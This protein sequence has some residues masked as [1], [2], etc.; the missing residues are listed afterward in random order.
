MKHV[1]AFNLGL[2]FNMIAREDDALVAGIEQLAS[3]IGKHPADI[4]ELVDRHPHLFEDAVKDGMFSED[5]C[6]LAAMLLNRTAANNVIRH[7]KRHATV[8]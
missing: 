1:T 2:T 6:I 7:I 4:L 5:E 3:D 8:S